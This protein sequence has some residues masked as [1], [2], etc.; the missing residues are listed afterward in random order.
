MGGI[1]KLAYKLLVNDRAK[2]AALLV[3][4]SFSA[5][6]MIMTSSMFAGVLN[7]ESAAV[8][9]IGAKIRVMKSAV[10][11]VANSIENLSIAQRLE[12]PSRAW[13]IGPST[14][15]ILSDA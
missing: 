2:F 4:F 12:W 3:R 7:R 14:S 6:L 10:N 11:N 5:F 15:E 9:N 1:L 13:P 8:I